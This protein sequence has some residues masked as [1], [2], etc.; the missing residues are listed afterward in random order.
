MKA[1]KQFELE[2]APL[3]VEYKRLNLLAVDARGQLED[4][5]SILG[6]EISNNSFKV[7][8]IPQTQTVYDE[9]KILARAGISRDQAI[10]EGL[11]K[12]TQR[13]SR[14]GVRELTDIET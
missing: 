5:V 11:I 14:V 7:T 10:A 3:F 1:V 2:N 9:E 8:V 4:E 12:V 13:P 6:S